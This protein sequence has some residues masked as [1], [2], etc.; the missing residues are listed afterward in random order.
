[1][2]GIRVRFLASTAVM[3]LLSAAAGGALADPPAGAKPDS[4]STTL[5]AAANG[6]INSGGDE[7]PVTA[8]IGPTEPTPAPAASVPDQS[9]P[10][11]PPAAST[12]PSA[13]PDRSPAAPAS[14]APATAAVPAAQPAGSPAEP[15]AAIAAQLHE[16]ADG[17]FDSLIGK[18]DGAVLDAFYSGRNY[19]PLWVTDGA[20]NARAK[21]AVAYLGEVDADGLEPSDYPVP[22]F[23]GVSDPTAQAQ[24]EIRLTASVIA[25]AHHASVGRVHWT[26][27]SG[28][29]YYDQKPPEPADV[30]AAIATASDVSAALD[31]YEPH[32]P[33]Y[34][35]LKAKL[36]ERRAGKNAFAHPIP[37]GPVLKVGSQ[38]DRVPVLRERLDVPGDGGT[39]YD[40]P[41]A[42]AVTKF[43]QT[44]DLKPTGTLTAATTDALNGRHPDRPIDI[45]LA[46]MERWRWMPHDLGK[47]YVMVNL[48]DYYLHVVQNG[49]EVWTTKVVD[50][51]PA[52]PTPITTAEMK[53]ITV[54]P[55]WNVPPSIVAKEY[56][57][58]LAQDPTILARMGLNVTRNPDGTAHI[59][60]PPGDNNALGRLRFNFPNK[61]LVYQHDSNEKYL[62]ADAMRARSHGCMRVQDPVKYAEVLLSI[63]RPGEGYTQD[64]IRRMF[65]NN[66]ADIQFPTFIP[67]HLTY[68]T[69]FVDEAGKLQFRDDMYGRDRALIGILKGDERKVADIP[70]ER[71]DNAIRR[72]LLA[73][74]DSPTFWGGRVFYSAGFGD[75]FFARLFN[76]F[77]YQQQPQQTVQRRGVAQHRTSEAH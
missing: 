45:I 66:E 67:V 12:N 15:D 49:K 46:N 27:V 43:Q 74:P 9:S 44:H 65:G 55:T 71:K 50:G 60:Q 7:V 76:P 14:A 25:Y 19:A 56:L 10:S 54:N 16:L 69:A 42:E 20:A 5:P 47:T 21:A 62:F 77:G 26:R 33:G 37:S 72:E 4:A 61:F 40:K 52:T 32:A 73:L 1:M 75:G 17:K 30:L 64:R 2:S 31:A 13:S 3:I 35:A 38:D 24:A 53:Y 28:D 22:D 23:A 34:L 58:L 48:P 63:V 68:Q 57:P 59:S 51:K 36:A 39:T 41:L 6:A 11:V 8:A 29:I 70:I 18:K